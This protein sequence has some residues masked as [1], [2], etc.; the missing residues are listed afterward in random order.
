M[1]IPATQFAKDADPQVVN[2][3]GAWR[4]DRAVALWPMEDADETHLNIVQ[5][6]AAKTKWPSPLLSAWGDPAPAVAPAG[7]ISALFN[8]GGD[9]S[10]GDYG[11]FWRAC[12]SE[13]GLTNG[14]WAKLLDNP[15]ADV[16]WAR[17]TW[18]MCFRYTG[19]AMDGVTDH[20]S[21]AHNF[22]CGGLSAGVPT[23]PGAF[24]LFRTTA[25]VWTLRT[26]LSGTTPTDYTV[27]PT[28]PTSLS[29]MSFRFD[30]TNIVWDLWNVAGEHKT[31]VIAVTTGLRIASATQS[32]LL[33]TISA[34]GF[35]GGDVEHY[36]A[37]AIADYRMGDAEIQEF[38]ADFMHPVRQ[39]PIIEGATSEFA[40]HSVECTRVGTTI[41]FA[42]TTGLAT[43]TD[44]T[45]RFAIEIYDTADDSLVA[46]VTSAEIGSTALTFTKLTVSADA[47]DGIEADAEYRYRVLWGPTGALRPLHAG[48]HRFTTKS[49]KLAVV[50]DEHTLCGT[51]DWNYNSTGPVFGATGQGLRCWDATEQTSKSGWNLWQTLNALAAD[52]PDLIYVGGDLL[53]LAAVQA[54]SDFG[55][56]NMGMLRGCALARLQC[57]KLFRTAAVVYGAAHNHDATAKPYQQGVGIDCAAQKQATC[58]INA[59]FTRPGPLTYAADFGDIDAAENEGAVGAPEAAVPDLSW[60]KP[61]AS[62]AD[63]DKYCRTAADGPTGFFSN[64]SPLGNYWAMHFGRL[65]IL[66]TDIGRYATCPVPYGYYQFENPAWWQ[67]G[68]R[69]EAWVET[70]LAATDRTLI[71][72]FD[73]HPQGQ[74][75]DEPSGGDETHRYYGRCWERAIELRRA[76][77]WGISLSVYG[78]DHQASLRKYAN[79]GGHGALHVMAPRDSRYWNNDEWEV[80]YGRKEDEGAGGPAGIV[81]SFNYPGYALLTVDNL[82][83]TL[84]IKL[85]ACGYN[86]EYLTSKLTENIDPEGSRHLGKIYTSETSGD[87]V[88]VTLASGTR[89]VPFAIPESIWQ[90]ILAIEPLWYDDDG[91]DLGGCTPGTLTDGVITYDEGATW[92]GGDELYLLAIDENGDRTGPA[93]H[94]VAVVS[95]N[96]ATREIAVTIESGYG[97]AITSGRVSIGVVGDAGTPYRSALL[98]CDVR[99]AYTG[100][101]AFDRIE[102]GATLKLAGVVADTDVRVLSFPLDLSSFFDDPADLVVSAVT[103]AEPS[104]IG[105]PMGSPPGM[106]RVH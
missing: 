58:A 90:G 49:V 6:L 16:V 95:H 34:T 83:D 47:D 37:G 86:L 79:Y 52:A 67:L 1:I 74:V 70:I 77:R 84:T 15:A 56:V 12:R 81:K 31:Q 32:L 17:G 7:V 64:E 39:A 50:E 71:A 102:D 23:G 42:M 76:L 63:V 85:V 106:L 75:S 98:A 20:G 45:L 35:Q 82:N 73:H 30:G 11:P 69:Q 88:I 10:T 54:A 3:N 8:A 13:S 65:L 59:F 99:A 46:T 66:S 62:I 4:E 48:L 89:L 43:L 9:F 93:R 21:L 92:A 68:A 27:T 28:N 97:S 22:V 60:I 18:G 80:G 5:A 2:I 51:T 19:V 36:W 25:G 101:Y 105:P 53:M 104:I 100:T 38:V 14:T 94:R 72:L 57:S 91:G 29:F 78:H 87:D 103:P 26:C 55:D 96:P 40:T 24:R 41:T 61:D 44:A 33:G